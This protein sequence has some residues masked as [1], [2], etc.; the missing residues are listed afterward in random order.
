M[1]SLSKLTLLALIG[2]VP[3]CARA[4]APT[5][6]EAVAE[7]L[8]ANFDV[9]SARLRVDSARAERTIARALPPLGLASTPQVPWQYSATATLDAGP[10]RVYRTHVADR[11]VSASLADADDERRL[12][13]FSV[14]IAF[15]DE[16]LAEASRDVAREERR[17]LAQVLAADSA[18]F[19]AGD[20]PDRDLT[21]AE[22]EVARADAAFARAD[23]QVHE[24]RVALQVLMGRAAP[25]TAVGVRGDIEFRDIDLPDS[26]PARAGLNRPDLRAARERADQ[27][28]AASG[29]ARAQ[30]LPIPMLSVVYQPGGPF[31]NGTPYALGFG[32][33]LP[34]FS[35]NAGERSRAQAGVAAAEL[36]VEHARATVRNETV[37]ATD[38]F[39]AARMLAERYHGGLV[40]RASRSLAMM[41]YAYQAGAASLLELVDAIRTD[42]AVRMDD[43]TARH[44]YWV[45]VYNLTRATGVEFVP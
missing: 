39:R 22:L 3:M 18:R 10:Q 24:L 38:A 35:W 5:L 34:V 15:V 21:R 8:R 17:L 19:E 40:E 1:A 29:L 28:R 14:R 45:A 27:S 41:R 25:D 11:G 37:S 4:Q 30:L 42:A 12:V 31:A 9:V 23:A 26:L 7:A 13:A 16:L 2:T 43:I 20:I 36:A 32:V 33:Q 44:D 6:S